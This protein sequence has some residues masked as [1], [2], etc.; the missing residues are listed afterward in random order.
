M[1]VLRKPWRPKLHHELL[2]DSNVERVCMR[3]GLGCA[4]FWSVV[5]AMP[6]TEGFMI[7]RNCRISAQVLALLHVL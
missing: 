1:P 2:I 5:Y 4:S 7:V 6:S 3:F